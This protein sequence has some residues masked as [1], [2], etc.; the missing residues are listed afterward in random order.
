MIR[1][2]GVVH[3]GGGIGGT[4]IARP[5]A[6]LV[7]AEGVVVWRNLTENWRVRTRPEH[8][9]EAIHQAIQ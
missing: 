1:A 4:D 2:Y 3:Q 5:A 9:V 8:V 6:I 7:D